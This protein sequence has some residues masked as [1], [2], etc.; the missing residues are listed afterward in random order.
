MY[1][2]K[3]LL[4]RNAGHTYVTR[5]CWQT[6][7]IMSNCAAVAQESFYIITNVVQTC[8]SHKTPNFVTTVFMWAESLSKK[9]GRT[10]GGGD[11]GFCE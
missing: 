6:F 1:V 10:N 8:Q 3:L 9:T 5:P 4:K 7:R 2:L 11:C